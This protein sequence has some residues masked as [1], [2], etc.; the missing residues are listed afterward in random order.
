MKMV[1][2]GIYVLEKFL[3]C[4]GRDYCV[5]RVTKYSGEL[6]EEFAGLVYPSEENLRKERLTPMVDDMADD[7]K[8]RGAMYVFVEAVPV[9][10]SDDREFR[11][12]DSVDD[13]LSPF[14]FPE[15]TKNLF[16]EHFFG[17][18]ANMLGIKMG[19]MD[20]EDPENGTTSKS[21]YFYS[22]DELEY[23]KSDYHTPEAF[24]GLGAEQIAG[25][26]AD[27]PVLMTFAE[28]MTKGVNIFNDIHYH[29]KA[30]EIAEIISNIR[31]I[32]DK[33]EVGPLNFTAVENL[34]SNIK[35]NIRIR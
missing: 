6:P 20:L 15:D 17:T 5:A 25:Y 30:V 35:D 34:F 22:V 26:R 8:A 16:V 19:Y 9:E 1:I 32:N 10:G 21:F 31:Y 23:I 24:P 4:A 11:V 13:F 27:N 3:P 12:V 2:E 29:Q 14:N 33:G 28:A 7:M 18:R